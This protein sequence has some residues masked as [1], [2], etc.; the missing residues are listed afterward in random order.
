MDGHVKRCS[1]DGE[2][3]LKSIHGATDVM[4]TGL[5]GA[6]TRIAIDGATVLEQCKR[7]LNAHTER[8]TAEHSSQHSVRLTF[9]VAGIVAAWW[10]LPHSLRL[11]GRC[12]VS[13]F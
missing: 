8:V 1:E 5:Q 4:E 9:M 13:N 10:S 2:K 3:L 11:M 12:T 6:V 7:Q